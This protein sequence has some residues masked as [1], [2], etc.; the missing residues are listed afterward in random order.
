MGGEWL[1]LFFLVLF[2]LIFRFGILFLGFVLNE[3]GFFLVCDFGVFGVFFLLFY[4]FLE[5]DVFELVVF[6][7]VLVGDESLIF[8]LL[9]WFGVTGGRVHEEGSFIIIYKVIVLVFVLDF[10]VL[11]LF[12]VELFIVVVFT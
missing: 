8:E 7:V 11:F 3:S 2:G 9:F 12:H 10:E 5:L 6:L 1:L 4:F